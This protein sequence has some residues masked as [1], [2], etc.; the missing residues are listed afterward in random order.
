MNFFSKHLSLTKAT[1]TF[2]GVLGLS[3][4]AVA[5]IAARVTFV[6]G[7]VSVI[8]SNNNKRSVFKGDLIR[9]GEKI[10]TANGRVQ[11][12]MTDGGIIVLR[13][14]S[15]FEIS[16][17][18]F[19][20]DTPELGTV[21]FNFIKGGARA[22]SGAIGKA[23]RVN[24]QFKT[25]IAT[26][27]I[28]GT[29][30]STTVS[31]DGKMVVTVN[32]GSVNL[33]NDVADVNVD[34]GES[35]T[36]TKTTPPERCHSNTN[37]DAPQE[38]AVKDCQPAIIPLETEDGVYFSKEK[39]KKPL[40]ENFSNYGAYLEAM[41]H[42]EKFEDTYMS[43]TTNTPILTNATPTLIEKSKTSNTDN[44][45]M[46]L[47]LL[48]NN[49]LNTTELRDTSIASTIGIQPDAPPSLLKTIEL[50]DLL[51]IKAF[52]S[53]TLEDL[54]AA[55][56]DLLDQQ[57]DDELANLI[58][59]FLSLNSQN[60]LGNNVSIT[61]ADFGTP[62][63]D[64][65]LGNNLFDAITVKLALE[66]RNQEYLTARGAL[67]LDTL[68]ELDENKNNVFR[69]VSFRQGLLHDNDGIAS[70]K[71]S[72]SI[73]I[74]DGSLE[75]STLVF[76][77]DSSALKLNLSLA[78]G[79][80]LN[81]VDPSL[82]KVNVNVPKLVIKLGDIY[83]SNSDSSAANINKNGGDDF[84][85]AAVLGTSQD[86]GPAV[87]IMGA[88]EIILGAAT[89]NAKLQHNRNAPN[90]ATVNGINIIPSVTI[91]AD[92][93]IRDGLTIKN[94]DI[95]DAGGSI[96]GGSLMIDSF[97]LSNHDSPDL[98]A[99]LSVNIEQQ[100]KG[101]NATVGG[102][103]LTLQQL[104][105]AIHGVD[106][107]MNNLRVGTRQAQNIGDVQIIGLDLNGTY[108]IMRGH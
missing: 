86:G 92:A 14:N 54:L 90:I 67:N 42:Y 73:V 56:N 64:V 33:A 84:G 45:N 1:V 58:S 107:A 17:Y 79:A 3:T 104:G 9:G 81:A 4:P 69:G 50:K 37:I 39:V 12:R 96:S 21:L 72:G 101:T 60:F 16:R 108:V 28:R 51:Q 30:Y 11:V 52:K 25:P 19:S 83:V 47:G 2:L 61:G 87:K 22:I 41:R 100:G 18:S 40:L 6:T 8:D 55:N 93:F 23:N 74:G 95:K 24:Y 103:L 98:T 27:G 13:P 68:A 31:N 26:I 89:I 85:A 91:L 75:Q 44:S 105:D 70:N 36:I 99:K 7:Q 88:S 46:L 63:I 82:L 77:D 49:A 71:N 62:D 20:R 94:I 76:T 65:I 66:K 5:D 43:Q 53:V 32:K 78:E 80:Q 34:E 15:I 102:L 97:K 38:Q 57:L 35:Y 48:S 29:D 59:D 106:I 10:E